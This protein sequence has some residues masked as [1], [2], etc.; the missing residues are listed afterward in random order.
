MPEDV[1]NV[2]NISQRGE[3]LRKQGVG[4]IFRAMGQTA[5]AEYYDAL[6]EKERNP[7]AAYR[8]AQTLK[9]LEKMKTPEEINKL[10]A[11]T[12]QSLMAGKLSESRYR[13]IDRLSD[14]M[15]RE[16]QLG[17]DE[18]AAE[19]AQWISVLVPTG[20]EG[21][22]EEG[23]MKVADIVDLLAG[24]YAGSDIPERKFEWESSTKEQQEAT[25]VDAIVRDK[26]KS[27]EALA[28]YKNFNR[29]SDKPEVLVNPTGKK[30]ERIP[31]EKFEGRV[32]TAKDVNQAAEELGLDV[33]TL[34]QMAQER[35]IGIV[36][37][38]QQLA[39]DAGYGK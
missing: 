15:L 20:T 32:V 35:G 24:K 13:E 3:E 27:D 8:Q 14:E 18:R 21:K 19:I 38:I 30:V 39:R 11:E 17:N 10:K 34:Y 28:Q 9:I 6:A 37:L 1:T 16:K 23:T 36:A 4:D 26:P 31:L 25:A 33:D 7:E 5:Q 2:M 29:Y 12:Y 22:Y